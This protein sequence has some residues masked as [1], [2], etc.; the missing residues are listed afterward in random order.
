MVFLRPCTDFLLEED[1]R[2]RGLKGKASLIHSFDAVVI[3]SI[4]YIHNNLCNRRQAGKQG[5][6]SAISDVK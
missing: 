1:I 4:L 6:A 5:L 2:V 3:E